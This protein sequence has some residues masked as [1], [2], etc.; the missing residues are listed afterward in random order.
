[1]TLFKNHCDCCN[2]EHVFLFADGRRCY[3]GFLNKKERKTMPTSLLTNR[4][5]NH[6]SDGRASI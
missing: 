4:P 5:W 3:E 6:E 2:L 1:M